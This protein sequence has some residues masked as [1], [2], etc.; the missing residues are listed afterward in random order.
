[1]FVRSLYNFQVNRPGVRGGGD[2]EQTNQLS[3]SQAPGPRPW[4]DVMALNDLN[5]TPS[6]T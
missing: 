2:N 1:M 3:I 6:L 5:H 4:W